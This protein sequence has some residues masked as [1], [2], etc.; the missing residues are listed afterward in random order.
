MTGVRARDFYQRLMGEGDDTIAR[1]QLDNSQ[2]RNVSLLRMVL[3]HRRLAKLT[4]GR[5]LGYCGLSELNAQEQ[6][7]LKVRP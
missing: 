3:A 5:N 7:W 1:K 2:V 4:G 6:E